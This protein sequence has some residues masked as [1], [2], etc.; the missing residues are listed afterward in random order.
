MCAFI[1]RPG[2]GTF[3]LW[4]PRSAYCTSETQKPAPKIDL[5][6][7]IPIIPIIA[8]IRATSQGNSEKKWADFREFWGFGTSK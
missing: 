7:I 5:T 6:P 8:T 4:D 1:G 3:G 2:G